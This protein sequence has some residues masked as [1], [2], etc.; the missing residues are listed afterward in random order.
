MAPPITNVHVDCLSTIGRAAL[1]WE[2]GG[3]RYHVWIDT[4]EQPAKWAPD[5]VYK[6]P[7]LGIKSGDPGNFHTRRLNPRAGANAAMLSEAVRQVIE[8]GLVVQAKV[9]EQAKEEQAHAAALAAEAAER[10]RDAAHDLLAVV[11]MVADLYQPGKTH[12]LDAVQEAARAAIA[13]AEAGS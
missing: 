12:T 7:P 6:N 5:K 3:A 9:A 1:G 2:Y 8:W 11:R 4:G 13:S 10:V